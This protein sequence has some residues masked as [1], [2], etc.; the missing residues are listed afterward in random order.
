MSIADGRSARAVP[1]LEASTGSTGTLLGGDRFCLEVPA[2]SGLR[3]RGRVILHL[4][5]SFLLQTRRPQFSSALEHGIGH[6]SQ[7]RIDALEVTQHIKM[8]GAGD[9]TLNLALTQPL[10]V[11]FRPR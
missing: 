7:M 11:L 3:L 6:G 5:Q 1:L 2:V 4:A 10:N 8:D 9:D